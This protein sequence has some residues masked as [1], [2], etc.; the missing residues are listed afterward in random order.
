VRAAGPQPT[1]A[2]PAAL[3]LEHVSV[4][5]GGADALVDLTVEFPAGASVAVLGPNGAGKSTLFRAV[6]GLVS[7]RGGRIELGTDRIAFVPQGIDIEPGFPVTATD[8]VRM[9][10][11]G[12]VGWLRRLGPRD[13]DLIAAG[14]DALGIGHLADRRFGDLSGG[15]RQRVLLAQAVAQD[16]QLLLLDEPFTGVD[17]PTREA[18]G[19]LLRRWTDEGRTVV[20][21]THDLESAAR[22]YDLVLC[23]NRRLVAFGPATETCTEAVLA[24]TFAGHVLRVGELLVDVAHH[25]HGAG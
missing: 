4:A 19:D 5:F 23:L 21:A 22:D 18:V 11:Y 13:L 8:V 10:R 2:A 9:G 1:P 24:E 20:V 12:D 17:R 16:A 25:H 6:I 3:H 15:E 7:A 14:L